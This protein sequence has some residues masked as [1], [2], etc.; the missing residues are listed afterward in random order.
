[1]ICKHCR[2]QLGKTTEKDR[3]RRNVYRK[4]CPHCGKTTERYYSK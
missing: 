1:M 3:V 2:A 4:R